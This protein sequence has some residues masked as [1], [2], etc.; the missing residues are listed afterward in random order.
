MYTWNMFLKYITKSKQNHSL[1]KCNGDECSTVLNTPKWAATTDNKSQ[2]AVNEVELSAW[3][4]CTG[5][6]VNA[7]SMSSTL[8]QALYLLPPVNS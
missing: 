3:V 4:P 5:S 6:D 2:D 1:L 8:L 7:I